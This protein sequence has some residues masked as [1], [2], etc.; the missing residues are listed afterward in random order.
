MGFST[1]NGPAS[2][3]FVTR[4]VTGSIPQE[5][6]KFDGKLRENARSVSS[7]KNAVIVFFP[8]GTSQV[9]SIDS[10]RRR[11]FLERPRILNFEAVTDASSTAGKFKF[12]MT[13]DERHKYWEEMEQAVIST[14]MS[15]SGHPLPMDAGIDENSLFAPNKETKGVAA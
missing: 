10:A 14:C 7:L 8:N 2:L 5:T 12:A 15:R 6:V 1:D 3:E 11:G 4:L 9:F 13:D